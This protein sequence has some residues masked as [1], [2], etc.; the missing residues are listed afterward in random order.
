[1]VGAGKGDQRSLNYFVKTTPEGD[2][3]YVCV[4]Q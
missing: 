4:N 3:M 1:M 2:K